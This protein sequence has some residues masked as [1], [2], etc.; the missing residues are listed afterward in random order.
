[1]PL[2]SY[3]IDVPINVFRGQR[4]V[5]L[6]VGRYETSDPE[7]IRIIHSYPNVR[8][9]GSKPTPAAT[10]VGGQENPEP[11]PTEPALRTVPGL[12]MR[13]RRPQGGRVAD[14]E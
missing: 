7:V 13:V 2:N 9:L 14:S 10:C 1:M 12:Q 11:V 5:V 8:F 6:P 3:Q 4:H